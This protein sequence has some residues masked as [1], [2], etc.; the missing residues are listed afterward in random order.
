[1]ISLPMWRWRPRQDFKSASK[2]KR[3]GGPTRPVLPFENKGEFWGL[4]NRE[5]GFRLN[6][7]EH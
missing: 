5:T 1:M 2:I 4:P 6:P 3:L 7:L